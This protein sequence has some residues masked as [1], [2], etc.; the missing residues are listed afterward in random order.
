MFLHP[1]RPPVRSPN[2]TT[3]RYLRTLQYHQQHQQ[4]T[5]TF[6][7]VFIGDLGHD[8]GVQTTEK[9]EKDALLHASAVLEPAKV[10]PVDGSPHTG[11][12]R[13]RIPVPQEPTTTLQPCARTSHTTYSHSTGNHVR[14]HMRRKNLQ[15]M[16]KP[17]GQSHQGSHKT[18]RTNNS[19]QRARERQLQT[20]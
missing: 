12:R 20:L 2:N 14:D 13:S 17:R 5:L 18:K 19:S 6:E 10:L 16:S 15:H 8:R 7:A 9:P 4:R 3:T 1:P 11:R